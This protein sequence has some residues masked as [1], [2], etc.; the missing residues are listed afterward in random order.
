MKEPTSSE[1][2][3]LGSGTKWDDDAFEVKNLQGAFGKAEYMAAYGIPTL[4]RHDQE[5]GLTGGAFKELCEELNIEQRLGLPNKP[6]TNGRVE[7]QVRNANYALKSLTLAQGSK[8]K[9][10]KEL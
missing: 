3:E 5:K 7:A 1:F 4:V 10:P 2:Q 8:G 6:Q 9:W